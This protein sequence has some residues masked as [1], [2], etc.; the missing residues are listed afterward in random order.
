MRCAWEAFINL[1]PPWMR[2]TV[3]IHG[4][5][6]LQELRLR[7][8]SPPELITSNG[9]I[10]LQRHVSAEDLR[11]C[12][13]ISSR[14]SPW[15]AD[16]IGNGYL[17]APGG[18]R[19]GIC[20]SA[21]I[22]EGRMTGISSVTS[23]CIR[24]AKDFPGIASKIPH[25][26]GSVLII[27][28]PG[29]GKTTLLRDLIRQISNH[30]DGSVAVVDEREEIF[31]MVHGQFCFS[32]GRKTDVLLSCGKPQGIDVVLRS[33][34]PAVIA[35]D[36]I[37]AQEDCQ[38]LLRA[39]WCGVKLLATAHAGDKND[40]FSRPIYRPLLEKKVFDT[41]LILRPDKSW[42]LERLKT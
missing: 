19:I 7:L 27:G 25:D 34:G 3:D 40:L 22:K 14:Y 18:H 39:G 38:A 31:P 16:S 28:R 2:D 5:N 20:G 13:N 36:E 4:K 26:S 6:T 41:L 8:N 42:Y 11:F 24:V 12:I 9:N 15:T 33:M 37:T 32:I 30:E 23:L 17:T 21:V 10:I 1:L 35:L 29:S